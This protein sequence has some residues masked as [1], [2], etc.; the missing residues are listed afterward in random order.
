METLLRAYTDPGAHRD[1]RA[2]IA[3]A[4]RE[5]L[6]DEE[7]WTILAAAAA[8]S[9]EE[10]RAVLAAGPYGMADRFRPRYVALLVAAC[11]AADPDVR[12]TA[13][14]QLPEWAPWAAD[15][16]D[17]IA[18]RLADLDEKV[19]EHQAGRL[20]FVLDEDRLVATMDR[21]ADREAADDRPGGGAVDRPARR[22]I[23]A[24]AE[25]AASRSQYVPV[26]TDR[27]AL[28]AAARRLAVRPTHTGT[29]IVMLTA[30]GGLR[31]LDEIADLCAD[32][33]V[34]A[35]RAQ[36]QV[37][38]GWYRTGLPPEELSATAARLAARGDLAGGL[39]AVAL[40]DRGG[41]YAWP[42]PW[43]GLLTELRRHPDATV[44]EE[45]YA[46]DMTT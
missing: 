27:S 32:R 17:L 6:G 36:Q 23:E 11:R 33:P 41:R 34:L 38:A 9:P 20:A 31:N 30:L 14:D 2:A 3:S 26:A 25:G 21:L 43:R 8:G 16:G 1:V 35:V 10:C 29:G 4:A 44:R 46:C 28:L 37:G 22:R 24:I 15:L 19:S 7:S 40:T 5:R 45:A 39:L 12:G 13:F 42:Q 18:H